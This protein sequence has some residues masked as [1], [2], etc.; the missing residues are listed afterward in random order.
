M[1]YA[2]KLVAGPVGSHSNAYFD[3]DSHS[4]RGDADSVTI[5]S[6]HLLFSGD[7]ERSGTDLIVSD[8]D[9][10]VVVSDYFQ[11]EKRPT[12]VSPEGAQLDSAGIEA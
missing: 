1:N 9:H 12:L 10:R 2:G 3:F 8:R 11:G 4:H 7:Y 5:P 6:A